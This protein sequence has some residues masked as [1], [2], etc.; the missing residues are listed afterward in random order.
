[1]KSGTVAIGLTNHFVM[2][3]GA[4]IAIGCTNYLQDI[5]GEAMKSGTIVMAWTNHLQ[6]L[7]RR[8]MSESIVLG[9]TTICKS[10]RE[11]QRILG[12][13]LWA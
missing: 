5:G 9:N 13:M 1:M 4:M 10:W 6:V 11:K 3:R 12:L 2:G 8:A 7:W